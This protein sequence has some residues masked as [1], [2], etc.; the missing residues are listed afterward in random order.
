MEQYFIQTSRKYEINLNTQKNLHKK[1]KQLT[2]K[3]FKQYLLILYLSHILLF[4]SIVF[5]SQKLS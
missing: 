4:E 5:L 3:I 1:L 2:I